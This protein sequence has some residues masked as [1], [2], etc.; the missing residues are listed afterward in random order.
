LSTPSRPV[1]PEP[2]GQQRRITSEE[3][4]AILARAD[5]LNVRIAR[6]LEEYG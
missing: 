3:E 2:V 5:E 4:A 6:I 1:D